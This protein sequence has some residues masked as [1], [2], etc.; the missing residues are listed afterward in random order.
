MAYK[1]NSSNYANVRGTNSRDRIYNYGAYAKVLGRNS[2]DYLYNYGKRATISG[3]NGNDTIDNSSYGDYASLSGGSGRDSINAGSYSYNVTLNGGK[4]ND[5]LTG[6]TSTSYGDVFQFGNYDGYDVITN[7]GE[8]DTI[9]LTGVYYSSSIGT[10]Y[11]NGDD[12][13]IYTSGGSITLKDAADSPITIALANG[14]TYV[15]NDDGDEDEDDWDDDDADADSDGDYEDDDDD[16]NYNNGNSN[17]YSSYNTVSNSTDYKTVYGTSSN[18]SIYNLGDHSDIFAYS[19]NDTIVTGNYYG[20]Y[21]SISAGAGNDLIKIGTNIRGATINGGAGNDTITAS[22]KY[23]GVFQFGNYDGYDVITNYGT[24]D[25]IHLTGVY[26]A[27]NIGSNYASGSDY[28]IYT[29]G[30]KITLQ[31]AASKKIKVKLASGSMTTLNSSYS[32]N[33]AELFTEDEF[34]NT[35][36]PVKLDSIVE[37]K[38]IGEFENAQPAQLNAEQTLITYTDK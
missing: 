19:G 9:H 14:T 25:T 5:T 4:G 11:A 28:V 10:N 18:D 35:A 6:S 20:E 8:N 34:T 22:T 24:N 13:I 37:N 38:N 36:E 2:A 32:Y 12:Y 27:S 21:S 23:S 29:S 15:L 31:N 30:G 33:I 7:Y 26:Y 17:G 16:Y 3:G 1:S